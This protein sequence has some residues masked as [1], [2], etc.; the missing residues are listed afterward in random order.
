VNIFLDQG[1]IVIG[2]GAVRPGDQYHHGLAEFCGTVSFPLLFP[3]SG[4]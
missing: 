3:L 4:R 1:R 2:A